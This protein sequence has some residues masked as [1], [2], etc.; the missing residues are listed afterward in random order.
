MRGMPQ[1][2]PIG[3]SEYLKTTDAHELINLGICTSAPDDWPHCGLRN[4]ADR[5]MCVN[6]LGGVLSAP[7]LLEQVLSLEQRDVHHRSEMA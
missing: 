5:P 6:L 4:L 7:P 1:E 3:K 2:A